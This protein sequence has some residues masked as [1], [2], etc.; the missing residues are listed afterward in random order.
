[1]G[2]ALNILMVAAEN[3]ALPKGKV[4][5]IGDVVRDVPPDQQRVDGLP[6]VSLLERSKREGC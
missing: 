1:M 6:P 5:G 3:D 2:T 4:G